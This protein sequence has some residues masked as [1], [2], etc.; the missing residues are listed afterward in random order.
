MR[1]RT[2]GPAGLLVA[3]L[4][5]PALVV[6]P[7]AGEAEAPRA[8][9]SYAVISTK[10]SASTIQVGER[11]VFKGRVRPRRDRQFIDLER[12]LDGHW[13]DV[14][15]SLTLEDGK[16]RFAVRPRRPGLARYR[17]DF[18]PYQDAPSVYGRVVKVQITADAP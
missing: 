17:V 10:V 7:A 15:E 11:L 9:A 1:N 8:T 4:L 3:G 5:A 2:L 16:Y 18:H 12:K 6:P 14:R 13:R